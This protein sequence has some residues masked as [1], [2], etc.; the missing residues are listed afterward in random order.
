[1]SSDA[2]LKKAFERIE[3]VEGDITRQQVDAIVQPARNCWL[4]AANS[5]V[6]RP[7][8]LRSPRATVCRPSM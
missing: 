1:M 4:S 2:D 7:A 5:A 6:V 8:R 3:L